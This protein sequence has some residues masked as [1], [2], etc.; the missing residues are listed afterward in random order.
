MS[1]WIQVVGVIDS[2][3]GSGEILGVQPSQAPMTEYESD[4]TTKLVALG[5][6]GAALAEAIVVLDFGSCADESKLGSFQTFMD[7]PD[8]TDSLSLQR[9]GAE[10]A[11]FKPDSPEATAGGESFGFTPQAG[12]VVGLERSS[13]SDTNATYTLQARKKGMSVWE[14]LDIGVHKP[15]TAAVDLKQ[16][17]D[18]DAIEVRILKSSGFTNVEIDRKEI[19]FSS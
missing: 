8:G 15:E 10:I 4:G 6:D 16:F 18:A 19:D 9:D 14:T 12:H 11:Q 13:P 17:P 5:A 3:S 1:N 7:L 2:I